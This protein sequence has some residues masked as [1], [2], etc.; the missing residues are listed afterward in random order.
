[1][2]GKEMAN[3]ALGFPEFSAQQEAVHRPDLEIAVQ[4][5]EQLMEDPD[6]PVR[7]IRRQPARPAETEPL[8]ASVPS[9]LRMALAKRGVH[10]LYTHQADAF[11]LA[12]AGS[13]VVVVTP[14][15]SGKTL[16]YNL[17]VLNRIVAE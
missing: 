12:E 16:C 3:L 14:T 11:R 15:A 10:E 7:A 8:P 17:P 1:M 4:R 6:S 2:A 13:N 9:E 5:F